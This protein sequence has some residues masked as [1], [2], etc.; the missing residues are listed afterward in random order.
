MTAGSAVWYAKYDSNL[1]LL[2]LKTNL[3]GP[4]VDA[5]EVDSNEDYLYYIT[6]S[7]TSLVK[8]NAT[9]GE[10]EL[11]MTDTGSGLETTGRSKLFLDRYTS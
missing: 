6:H 7:A 4:T 10:T 9:T 2:Y 8:A 11:V 5:Y 3:N 1:N